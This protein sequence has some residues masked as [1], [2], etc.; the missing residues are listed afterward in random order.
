MHDSRVLIVGVGLL[1]APRFSDE[2]RRAVG[3]TLALVGAV[4]TVPLAFEVLGRRRPAPAAP[5]PES[6]RTHESGLEFRERLGQRP[7]VAAG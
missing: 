4:T 6:R 2:A 7:A 1:L 5:A 3:W